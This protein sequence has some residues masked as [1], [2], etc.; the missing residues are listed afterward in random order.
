MLLVGNAQHRNRHTYDRRRREGAGPA[1]DVWAL[2]CLLYELLTGDFL[3]HDPDWI[4]FFVRLVQPGQVPVSHVIPDSAVSY[5]CMSLWAP[6]SY[7]GLNLGT[8][9]VKRATFVGTG[10]ACDMPLKRLHDCRS[11]CLRSD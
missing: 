10:I 3:F 9:L 5:G 6:V 7:G 1:A 4:R 8:Q 11:C 2:G